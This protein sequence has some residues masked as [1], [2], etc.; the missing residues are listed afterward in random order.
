MKSL[1]FLSILIIPILLQISCG[2]RGKTGIEGNDNDN[3]SVI[4][5]DN[6]KIEHTYITQKT[7]GDIDQNFMSEIRLNTL[8][9]YVKEKYG[10]PH[11]KTMLE[12]KEYLVW[13]FPSLKFTLGTTEEMSINYLKYENFTG[14]LKFHFRES[15]DEFGINSILTTTYSDLNQKSYAV[16]KRNEQAGVK[17][18]LALKTRYGRAW[19]QEEVY[20]LSNPY[21]VAYC[22]LKEVDK[23]QISTIEI[24]PANQGISFEKYHE[25]VNINSDTASIV[26]IDKGFGCE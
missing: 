11:E 18:A 22:D 13:R 15:N 6:S 7:K 9:S 23:K 3:N 5:G 14:E 25:W 4:I 26:W 8:L 12:G 1:F 10:S 17:V 19:K 21:A 24:F 20:I 2:Q 16:I